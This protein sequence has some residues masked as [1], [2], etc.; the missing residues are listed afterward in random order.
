MLTLNKFTALY[1]ETSKNDGIAYYLEQPISYFYEKILFVM[2]G[3][4]NKFQWTFTWENKGMF[5]KVD[6]F[7]PY[8]L[9]S[10]AH[11]LFGKLKWLSRLIARY[12]LQTGHIRV[13]WKAK[14]FTGSVT[15]FSGL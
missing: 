14:G 6:G 12:C 4:Q 11:G 13:Q 3:T 1:A 8:C 10:S 7:F 15:Y 2:D 9:C 5:E